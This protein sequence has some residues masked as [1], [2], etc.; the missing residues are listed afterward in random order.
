[1]VGFKKGGQFLEDICWSVWRYSSLY[2]LLDDT[3]VSPS[4]C[5]IF[6]CF[7]YLVLKNSGW[8]VL[9]IGFGQASRASLECKRSSPIFH[10]SIKSYI[11][12][13]RVCLHAQRYLCWI[14]HNLG[15][16][17]HFSTMKQCHIIQSPHWVIT[18]NSVQSET[19]S[20]RSS[21]WQKT[22]CC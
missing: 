1:M 2:S 6:P 21:C 4:L 20:P 18:F 16:H 19:N 17:R 13:D 11:A 3:W 22:P 8:L 15:R 10:P 14:L 7:C 12:S 9:R 5:L